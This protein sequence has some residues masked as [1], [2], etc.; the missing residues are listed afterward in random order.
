MIVSVTCYWNIQPAV[1][2]VYTPILIVFQVW[3][4]HLSKWLFN[5]ALNEKSIN[6]FSRQNNN[7]Y[8]NMIDMINQWIMFIKN[9][10][11]PISSFDE[12]DWFIFTQEI[13]IISICFSP[14][15]NCFL[16]T[17]TYTYGSSR[18][19]RCFIFMYSYWSSNTYNYMA[20]Q[21]Y[22]TVR[23]SHFR[24]VTKRNIRNNWHSFI[25][26][27]VSF[28]IGADKNESVLILRNISRF[29][30]G[31][32]DCSASNIL[33]TVNRQFFLYVK[34]KFKIFIV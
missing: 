30:A 18:R 6:L 10:V 4:L 19:S 24:Y 23:F 21:W 8:R 9:H 16:F 3:H 13:D 32:V 28:S 31:R 33:S 2:W 27:L 7:E 25:S 5:E 1:H 26:M 12:Q 15:S 34:C 22:I 14:T 17:R 11:D 29:D 20:C